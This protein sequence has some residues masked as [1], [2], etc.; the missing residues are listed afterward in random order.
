MLH[1]ECMPRSPAPALGVTTRQRE[2]LLEVKRHRSTPQSV[3]LRVNIVLG[4]S[5]GR[6]KPRLSARVGDECAHG[7]AVAP[8]IRLRRRDGDS[9]RP[10]PLRASETDHP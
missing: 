5:E 4:A 6:P 1:A 7:A 9:G 3:V 8:A 10:A 2:K